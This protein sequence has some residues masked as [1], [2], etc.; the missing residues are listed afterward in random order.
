MSFILAL[1]FDTHI[2]ESL[3]VGDT[4]Y[5]APVLPTNQEGFS[6]AN[7]GAIIRMGSVHSIT[8]GSSVV[9]EINNILVDEGTNALLSSA[10]PPTPSFIMFSKNKSVNTNGLTGYYAEVKF[11]NDSTEKIEL[12]SIASEV[13]ESSK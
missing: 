13:T 10:I 9:I 8:Y 4:A 3:Q 1:T 2:N 12:F 5:Y 11:E 6:T 7:S